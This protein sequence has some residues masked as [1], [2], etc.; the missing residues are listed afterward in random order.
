MSNTIN[1]SA[2][3]NEL[4]LIATTGVNSYTLA[5][6]KSGYFFDV[7]VAITILSGDYT[8]VQLING[9]SGPVN[10]SYTAYLP[11]GT[12]TIVAVCV[13]WGG[14]WS[15]NYNLNGGPSYSGYDASGVGAISTGPGLTVTQDPTNT[16]LI[17]SGLIPGTG[18]TTYNESGF[19]L[20]GALIQA[21]EYGVASPG[22]GTYSGSSTSKLTLKRIDGSS[23]NLKSIDMRNLNDQVGAQTSVITGTLSGGGTVSHTFTT[24]GSNV[25]YN[26]YTLPS[27]FTNLV[28]VIFGDGFVVTTNVKM[29]SQ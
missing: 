4:Y 27:T 8:E 28:S 10:K 13:N 17:F 2:C 21:S 18:V 12:Y 23:F 7:A 16:T 9:I 11:A 26:T 5:H 24:P 20:S 22:K 3:D 14:P 25:S 19:N 1:I 15:Y 6:V 29:S